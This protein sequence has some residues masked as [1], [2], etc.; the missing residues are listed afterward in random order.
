MRVPKAYKDL[1]PAL[2]TSNIHATL[3]KRIQ[4][5]Y[6]R[7]HITLVTLTNIMHLS[8]PSCGVKNTLFHS[9][10]TEPHLNLLANET[11]TLLHVAVA[12]YTK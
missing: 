2:S 1:N 7:N 9:L 12:V 5:Q 10:K 4:N 3:V 11:E 6:Y 8:C